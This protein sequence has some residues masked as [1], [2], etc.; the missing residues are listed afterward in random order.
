MLEKEVLYQTQARNSAGLAAVQS[1]AESVRKQ[2]DILKLLTSSNSPRDWLD[3]RKFQLVLH[4]VV[5]KEVRIW[6]FC[7]F[8]CYLFV[9]FGSLEETPEQWEI[10]IT[11][12][13]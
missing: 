13:A 11:S 1:P 5:V 3:L 4:T 12:Y 8:V 6:Q 7:P 2:S 10:K 9:S